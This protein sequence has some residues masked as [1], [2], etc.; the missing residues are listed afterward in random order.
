MQNFIVQDITVT[1][2]LGT[3]PEHNSS[4]YPKICTN[5]AVTQKLINSREFMI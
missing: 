4:L 1:L 3:Q 2:L 5:L